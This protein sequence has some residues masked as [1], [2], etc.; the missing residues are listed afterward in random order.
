MRAS[1]ISSLDAREDIKLVYN[2]AELRG[3]VRHACTQTDPTFSVQKGID[4]VQEVEEE[5]KVHED[6][7]F[8][9]NQVKWEKEKAAER[10]R[11]LIAQMNALR[12]SEM[13]SSDGIFEKFAVQV[14]FC[15]GSLSVSDLS[16]EY[17]RIKVDLRARDPLQLNSSEDTQ[18]IELGRID[19]NGHVEVAMTSESLA[20]TRHYETLSITCTLRA[21]SS[22]D[23]RISKLLGQASYPSFVPT[24]RTRRHPEKIML[25]FNGIGELHTEL[26]VT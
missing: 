9:S 3:V 14:R 20:L 2:T 24:M 12:D 23:D 16:S 15:G 1:E 10:E 8:L 22:V 17:D 21:T 19:A 7:I 18:S 6:M 4:E 11:L 13:V 26:A 25:V 5:S